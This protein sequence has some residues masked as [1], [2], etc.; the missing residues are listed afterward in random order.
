MLVSEIFCSIQG[1]GKNVG[2]PAVFLRL[3]GCNLKCKWCDTK[4]TWEEGNDN[5][6]LLLEDVLKEIKKYRLKHLVVTGGEPLLQQEELI[7]LLQQLPG[8]FVEVET[9]GSISS[10]IDDLV[11]Q[12]NCSPKLSNSGSEPYPLQIKPSPK[13]FYKFVV[14]QPKDIE[15]IDEY[16]Q[17][18]KI[19]LEF[20]Y[21]MP[22]GIKIKD[23]NEKSIWLADICKERGYNYSPRLQILLGIK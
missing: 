18:N 11:D 21:L 12:Y 7:D 22:Q 23:L 2:K 16:V 9:N 1:E 8:Y 4:Y 6:G 10:K 20:V 13:T 5:H 19:S 3:G 17:E 15:E 14:D